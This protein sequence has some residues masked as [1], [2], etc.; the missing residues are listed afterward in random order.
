MQAESLVDL[1]EMAMNLH[2]GQMSRLFDADPI[3]GR[4][5]YT[6]KVLQALLPRAKLQTVLGEAV[7]H[8]RKSSRR[9]TDGP[10]AG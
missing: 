7:D 4:D 9:T 3:A 10:V 6:S 1:A 8:R 5:D 2:L